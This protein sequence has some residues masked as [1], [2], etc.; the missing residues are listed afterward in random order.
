MRPSWTPG[1][2]RLRWPVSG[3]ILFKSYL[4]SCRMILHRD[5][6]DTETGKDG[7]MTAPGDSPNGAPA[8]EIHAAL[9]IRRPAAIDESI[10]AL[11][12]AK[13]FVVVSTH[14]RNGSIHGT[15][16]WVDTDGE[17]VLLNTEG[18]GRAWPRNAIRDPRITC[19]VV[20]MENPYEFVEIRGRAIGPIHE[21]A[22]EHA[23]FLA[24]KY[25]DLPGYPYH[26][27]EN[28]RVLFKVVPEKIVHMS[29]PLEGAL[30][31]ALER[32]SG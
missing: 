16:M 15:P 32:Q 30:P 7:L 19:T 23:D 2:L 25:L 11:L 31:D 24:S 14:A 5:S 1:A 6:R 10:A 4:I 9:A 29:P 20:N 3:L 27:P 26:D 21:G 8:Q 22:L 12:R 18:I 28:P 13:N 17:H